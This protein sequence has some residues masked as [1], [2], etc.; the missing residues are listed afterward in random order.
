MIQLNGQRQSGCSDDDVRVK[1]RQLYEASMKGKS[2][3]LEHIWKV[4]EKAPKWAQVK[5]KLQMDKRN[6]VTKVG[7]Y[8]TSSDGHFPVNLDD[9]S[10][11]SYEVRPMG[12]K[13][14]KR[15]AKGKAT[16][17]ESVT[18]KEFAV[19]HFKASMDARLKLKE[20]ERKDRKKLFKML[21]VQT[22]SQEFAYMYQDTSHMTKTQLEIFEK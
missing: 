20:K 6:K 18:Q 3:T 2:F 11:A 8:T 21:E 7:S 16:S 12:T 1:A 17:S 5:S 9:D 14:A 10:L 15:A 22:K 19:D 13:A 4:L